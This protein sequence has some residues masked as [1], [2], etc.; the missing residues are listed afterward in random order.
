MLKATSREV[1][2]KRHH[3]ANE[4]HGRELPGVA[5]IHGTERGHGD[6]DES[7]RVIEEL[8]GSANLN[9]RHDFLTFFGLEYR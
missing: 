2:H 9:S 4:H 5:D 7:Q 6:V 1:A 3:V 8:N